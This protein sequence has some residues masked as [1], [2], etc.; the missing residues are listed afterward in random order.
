VKQPYK[1]HT[2]RVNV[3][4]F[5]L[6]YQFISSFTGCTQCA[7][8]V[9]VSNLLMEVRPVIVD[10]FWIILYNHLQYSNKP[11]GVNLRCPARKGDLGL[12]VSTGKPG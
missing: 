8:G 12:K 3:G 5:D 7:G 11:K 1:G 9:P 4:I 6:F 10:T 2:I